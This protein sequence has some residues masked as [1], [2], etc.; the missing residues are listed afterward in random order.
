MPAFSAL[1][2]EDKIASIRV[3]VTRSVSTLRP[4]P[5]CAVSSI[6][7]R[8]AKVGPHHIL[9]LEIFVVPK[10]RKLFDCLLMSILFNI[11]NKN[12]SEML[13]LKVDNETITMSRGL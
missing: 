2:L 12:H 1:D 4:N 3:K 9:Q 13:P 8:K 5:K 10:N 7:T 11:T 6:S